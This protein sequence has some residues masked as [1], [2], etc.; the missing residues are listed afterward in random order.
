MRS[1]LRKLDAV[2]NPDDLALIG[3][4]VREK[5]LALAHAGAQGRAA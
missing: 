1:I 5:M 4:R 2:T 3:G